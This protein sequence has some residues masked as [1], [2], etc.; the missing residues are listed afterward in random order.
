MKHKKLINLLV[1]LVGNYLYACSVK[2]FVLSANLMGYGTTGI[3]LILNALFGIPLT[4]F[5]FVFNVAMLLLGWKFLGREFAMTTVISSLFYP[6]ALEALNR[7]L[8]DFRITDD[9]VLNAIF[10]GL[11]LFP[12]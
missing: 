3:S 10:A 5:I 7:I 12:I 9:A 1:V 11:I 8:E 2:L 6:I 4:T